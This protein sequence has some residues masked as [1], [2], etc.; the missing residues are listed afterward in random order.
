MDVFAQLERINKV[1]K[2]CKTATV[3]MFFVMSDLMSRMEAF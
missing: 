3:L 1:V 2:I